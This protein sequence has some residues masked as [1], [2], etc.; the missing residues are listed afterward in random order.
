MGTEEDLRLREMTRK[1]LGGANEGRALH[2]GNAGWTV[3][4][5]LMRMMAA[6]VGDQGTERNVDVRRVLR[7]VEAAED[8]RRSGIV[9][10]HQM[11]T[12]LAS[13]PLR[14][15]DGTLT[16]TVAAPEVGHGRP[17]DDAILTLKTMI[18]R[19]R[20]VDGAA[21]TLLVGAMVVGEA[22]VERSGTLTKIVITR[23]RKPEVTVRDDGRLAG[24]MVEIGEGPL[25]SGAMMELLLMVA[26]MNDAETRREAGRGE[27]TH[28]RVTVTWRK[29]V[30]E[31]VI[32]GR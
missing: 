12:E 21:H 17:R 6:L 27:T 23:G 22:L 25:E 11:E 3:T 26:E 13:D 15:K 5:T 2:V 10:G 30:D 9:N 14:R 29:G 31:T 8:S 18:G 24:V 7:R 19:R 32:I 4:W 28:P 1:Y 16:G 20:E